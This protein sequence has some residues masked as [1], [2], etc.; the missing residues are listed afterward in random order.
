MHWTLQLKHKCIF[1]HRTTARKQKRPSKH[2][3]LQHIPC[4]RVRAR[5]QRAHALTHE[6]P[7]HANVRTRRICSKNGGTCFVCTTPAHRA[8]R[9][10]WRTYVLA[11]L[12]ASTSRSLLARIT[13]LDIGW[14]VH[15][16]LALSWSPSKSCRNVACVPV[17][18]FT[19]LI[20]RSSMHRS[21]AAM[22]S[23]KS[24]V[25]ATERTI[26]QRYRAS[27]A[28]VAAAALMATIPVRPSI[29]RLRHAANQFDVCSA[30]VSDDPPSVRVPTRR[31][32][33]SLARDKNKTNKDTTYKQITPASTG[34]RASPR[35]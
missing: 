2:E 16:S 31:H 28:A 25:N 26:G 9:H 11:A 8:L 10:A 24:Y 15:F 20:G 33:I 1:T 14:W 29:G 18:P 12:T 4:A 27:A 7:R 34:W 5:R 17:V 22:S 3:R 32:T 13:W 19:P 6:Q 21:K 35:W 23:T 30:F